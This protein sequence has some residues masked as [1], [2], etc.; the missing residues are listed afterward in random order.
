MCILYNVHL[1]HRKN[2]QKYEYRINLV[3]STRHLKGPSEDDHQPIRVRRED[4]ID[5]NLLACI[6][7][8]GPRRRMCHLSGTR[9]AHDGHRA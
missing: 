5:V 6:V 2:S 4:G 1:K 8:S 7:D 9:T 3:H